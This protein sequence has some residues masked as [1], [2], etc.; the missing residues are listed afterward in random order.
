MR[1]SILRIGS[2]PGNDEEQA[3][4]ARA[5]QP[6]ESEDDA[7]LVLLDDLDRRAGQQDQDHDDDDHDDQRLHTQWLLDCEA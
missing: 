5:H 6:A 2:M 3:G 1:R 4:P 7:A